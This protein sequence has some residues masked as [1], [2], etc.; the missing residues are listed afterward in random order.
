MRNK[1]IFCTVLLL[2][3]PLLVLGQNVTITGKVNVPGALVRLLAYDEMLTCMQTKVAETQADKDGKFTLKATIKEIT[4]VQIAVNLERV[5]MILKPDANYD[6]EI[7]IPKQPTDVSYFEKEQPSLKIYS[8]TDDGL[9]A[10][11]VAAESLIDEFIYKNF[12]QI[13]RGRKTYLMD[14]IENQIIRNLGGI[15]S[16]YVKHFIKYRKASV[17]MTL[18]E[19]KVLSEYFDNQPVLYS[20]SAY[21]EAF[22]ELFGGYFNLRDFNQQELEKEMYSG[23]DRFMTYLKK[24]D[25]LSRNQQLCELVVMLELRRFYYENYHDKK[26]VKTFIETIRTQSDYPENRIVARNFLKQIN[27]LSYDSQAPSFSLKDKNGK[28]VKLSDYQDN[29][30]LLQFVERVSPMLDNEFLRLNE[31]HQQWGDTVQIITVATKESFDDYLQ[32]FDK[33]G[34]DW[35]L[36][37]LGDNILL[38]E[39][40]HTKTYP[41]YVILKRKNKVGM[42]PAPSPEQYLD[43]HIRRIR[44]H[45]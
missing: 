35:I 20:Q 19:K 31:L 5:D 33:Q 39:D 8:A 24:N 27:E 28:V 2:L 11:Y 37:N 16:D 26:L 22:S 10:Q 38:L 25:F 42:A 43:Y 18:N 45:L 4:P 7:F 40:Y 14:T 3:C 12:E 13:S 32:L 41:A 34:F 29:M 6:I 30:V 21:M 15:K 17:I 44:K 1:L 9:Y 36:L 23:Y